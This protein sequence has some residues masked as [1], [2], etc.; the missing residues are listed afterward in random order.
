MLVIALAA[1]S[2]YS[3]EPSSGAIMGT[4]YDSA[5]GKRLP[6]ANIIL[7]GTSKGATS[8]SEGRFLISGIPPGAYVV[9]A[10]MI[11]YDKAIMD[12][13][14]VKAGVPAP[15]ISAPGAVLLRTKRRGGPLC[16]PAT[17]LLTLEFRASSLD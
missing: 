9:Q 3:S 16:P 14:K 1:C 17:L 6:F 5:T 10:S 12:D 4:I 2:A 7:L 15:L 11:G 8:D 13:V